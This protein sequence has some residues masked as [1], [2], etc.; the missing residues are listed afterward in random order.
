[1]SV[2]LKDLRL[3]LRSLAKK[4]AYAGLAIAT[5]ALGLGAATAVYGVFDVV[6]LSPLPFPSSDRLMVL[7][8]ANPAKRIETAGVSAPEYR[9]YREQLSSF[10]SLD[11]WT[12]Y[13]LSLNRDGRPR[14]ITTLRASPGLL[15]TLGTR[16]LLGRTFRPDE[17]E[18][19]RVV[20]MSHGLWAS[21]FGADPGIIGRSV[22][23]DEEPWTVVGVMPAGFE[24]PSAEV[25]LWIP[26]STAEANER[27]RFWS[28]LGRLKPGVTE[29]QARREAETVSRALEAKY[30]D[31]NAGFVARIASLKER[32]VGTIRSSLVAVLVAVGLFLLIACANVTNLTLA[33]GLDRGGELA[34]RTALGA[35]RSRLLSLLLAEST[36]LALLGGL[37]GVAL[38]AWGVEA[39]SALAPAEIPRSAEITLSPRVL[40]VAGGLILLAGPLFGLLPAFQLSGRAGSAISGNRSMTGARA[41]T[42]ARRALTIAQLALS[43]VLL[44]GAGL[45]VRSLWK[46][47][48]LDPGFKPE[49]AVAVQLFVFG[50]QYEGKPDAWRQ[51]SRSLEAGIA[52]LPGVTAV[53]TVNALPLSPIQGGSREIQIEGRAEPEQLRAS[54]R[55]ASPGALAALGRRLVAGRNFTTDDRDGGAGVVMLSK[56]AVRAYFG[57]QDP[58]GASIRFRG[59]EKWAQVVGVVADVRAA[60][61]ERTP[62]PEV[63]YPY[64][65]QPFGVMSV[66]V[67]SAGNL[68]GLLEAV[69]REVWK[70]DAEQPVYRAAPLTD[71]VRQ[72]TA[73]RR[74]F[75]TVLAF[76]AFFALLLASIGIYGVVS[77]SVAQRLREIALRMALGANPAAIRQMV[78]R[79]GAILA[80]GGLGLGLIL[81]IAGAR[82]ASSMLFE[83]PPT[84]PTTFLVVTMVL[85]AVALSACLV[86]AYRAAA[87]APF[88]LLRQE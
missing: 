86:P 60:G 61:L 52:G 17:S 8:T 58:L 33:R 3:A 31:T 68:P 71:L 16:P 73:R 21:E 77:Y 55:I 11:L 76:F 30:P 32:A 45:M 69:Q 7:Y 28:V 40:A 87:V 81:G 34:A 25:K 75:T 29:E 46:V 10:A 12:W 9:D 72:D 54:F 49:N 20:V 38:A 15:E 13:G 64:E 1:M 88:A 59:S 19:S 2:F 6:L 44:A 62:D 82:A 26:Y 83:I 74:F 36:L 5:M 23:L 56:A 48:G 39:L 22:R 79:D 84:D 24:F 42:R 43:L 65:Q 47:F 67:R 78:L 53:G 80:A 50:P 18:E 51:F 70:V 35:P 85:A 57:D 27:L 14:D 37:L 63:I 41:A 4:P 66:V